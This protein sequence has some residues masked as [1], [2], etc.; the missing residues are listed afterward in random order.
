MLERLISSKTAEKKP[1]LMFF[2]GLIYGFLSLFLVHIFFSN[3]P[4]F[5]KYSGILIVVFCVMFS[6]PYIYF[7]I[8]REEK[9][10]ELINGVSQ[11]WKMHGDAIL[12]FMWL[13]LGFVISFSVGY[14]VLKDPNLLNAQIET[15]CNINSPGH[16]EE[17]VKKYSLTG[18]FF[19]GSSLDKK[20]RFMLII[21]NNF[22]VLILTLV[23]SLIFGAGAIFILAWN[24]SVIA[25]A[26]GVFTQNSLNKI[27]LG[28][29]R[30]MI[31][32]FPEIVAYFIAA[33]AGGIFGA[34]LL[35]NGLDNRRFMKVFMNVITLMLI[36]ML[37]LLFAG[38]IEVYLT[39]IIFSD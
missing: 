1:W 5:S 28:L 19:S 11:V 15:Y 17:C 39:P 9:E 26:I 37:I 35:R 24:A 20:S 32:G 7:A 21:G 38:L 12:A 10:D 34:G 29:G 36:A 6:L 13:F 3:D 31:H 14:M 33:L 25:A 22:G 30:Y 27:P 4:V 16:V 18:N 8:K 23:F 2:I